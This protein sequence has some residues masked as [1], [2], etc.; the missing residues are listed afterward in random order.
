MIPLIP[1]PGSPKTTSTPQSRIVSMRMSDAVVAMC[2]GLPRRLGFLSS[3]RRQPACQV[4]RSSAQGARGRQKGPVPARSE[5]WEGDDYPVMF[6]DLRH[7]ACP[8][9]ADA[10]DATTATPPD[11]RRSVICRSGLDVLRLASEQAPPMQ[12]VVESLG[13]DLEARG[14]PRPVVVLRGQRAQDELLLD[15]SQG[16][17]EGH[18]HRFGVLLPDR[19]RRGNV[20]ASEAGQR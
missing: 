1:S 15:L 12:H 3:W 16:P 11:G 13:A 17:P 5:E 4:D 9:M 6:A 18:R 20:T 10:R 2:V 14:G 7:A 8:R 19:H